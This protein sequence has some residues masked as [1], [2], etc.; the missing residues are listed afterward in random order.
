MTCN[1]GFKEECHNLII[2]ILSQFTGKN[3]S[4]I[5]LEDSLPQVLGDK[6]IEEFFNFSDFGDPDKPDNFRSPHPCFTG[7]H[8][9]VP[10]AIFRYQPDVIT[11]SSS[12]VKTWYGRSL[13]NTVAG[14]IEACNGIITMDAPST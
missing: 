8:R 1:D 12:G 6:G 10:R 7:E 4:D 3:K 14:L 5:R 9:P 13:P 2:D 11:S